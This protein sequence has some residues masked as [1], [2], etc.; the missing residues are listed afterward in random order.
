MI[1]SYMLCLDYLSG[2]LRFARN[3]VI[4]RSE[5]TKQSR[6]TRHQTKTPSINTIKLYAQFRLL[7][8]Q[9]RHQQLRDE[10]RREERRRDAYDERDG[11]TAY[12]A[13]SLPQKD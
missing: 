11:E 10:E 13:R 1:E 8:E 2:L 7:I 12:R 9:R 5:A 3:D 4:A 6:K